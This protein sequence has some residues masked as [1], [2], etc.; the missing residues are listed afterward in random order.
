MPRP[1]QI[2]TQRADRSSAAAIKLRVCLA[3]ATLIYASGA[4]ITVVVGTRR[5]LQLM[6]AAGLKDYAFQLQDMDAL[7]CYVLSLPPYAKIG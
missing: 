1:S 4:G 5:A 3:A 6:C 2:H 7:Y